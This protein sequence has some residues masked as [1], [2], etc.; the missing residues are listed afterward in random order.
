MKKRLF[1]GLLALTLAVSMLAAAPAQAAKAVMNRKGISWDLKLGKK[2]SYKTKYVSI[3]TKTDKVR[4][5]Q[6]KL[7]K[8]T[9][10]Y[11]T[12]DVT[13]DF[14][15][16][17]KLS[18]KQVYKMVTSKTFR[19]KNLLGGS[20]YY[21]VVDYDT[22]ICLENK[23]KFD[24]TVTVLEDWRTTASHL[25]K[26]KKGSWVR[27]NDRQ[28]SFR[29][30]YPASYTGLCIGAG[31][32]TGLTFNSN[33]NKFF[34]GKATFAKATSLYSKKNKKFAHFMRIK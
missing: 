5:T 18:K 6:C 19:K 24:V 8:G 25:F 20:F 31:G 30:R 23:N 12:L 16:T 1:A 2:V 29:V 27:L 13:L 28:V 15:R 34:D 10:G 11:N 33:T 4:L 7:T 26:G 17:T 9:D 3:G 14:L 21:T 32:C 22:G